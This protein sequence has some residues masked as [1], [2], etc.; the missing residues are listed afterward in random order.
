VLAQSVPKSFQ[1]N[2]LGQQYRDSSASRA[3]RQN[4]ATFVDEPPANGEKPWQVSLDFVNELLMSILRR[5]RM[6]VNDP[7]K[8]A[9]A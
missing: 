4:D 9:A 7:K 2:L 1:Q 6:C 8:A 3:R 5:P